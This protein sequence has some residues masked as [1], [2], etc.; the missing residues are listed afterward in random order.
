MDERLAG[1]D[2]GDR[3]N[4]A[5]WGLAPGDRDFG[6]RSWADPRGL[7]RG[8]LPYGFGFG[9][10]VM[11]YLCPHRVRPRSLGARRDPPGGGRQELA[12]RIVTRVLVMTPSRLSDVRLSRLIFWGAGF[13]SPGPQHRPRGLRATRI[14][15]DHTLR[16]PHD[17]SSGPRAHHRRPTHG[18]RNRRPGDTRGCVRPQSPLTTGSPRLRR[19]RNPAGAVGVSTGELNP[20]GPRTPLQDPGILGVV[21][22]GSADDGSAN[23]G[24]AMA[25]REED[26]RQVGA[27]LLDG[28]QEPACLSLPSRS[29]SPCSRDP[30]LEAAGKLLDCVDNRQAPAHSWYISRG[31]CRRGRQR[32]CSGRGIRW[33]RAAAC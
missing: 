27:T 3:W 31:H 25:D 15:H 16:P 17:V 8:D 2:I 33:G 12:A 28:T 32:L 21:V 7:G 20:G 29:C 23:A 10:G 24:A 6:V 5:L 22:G 30:Y 11:I 1:I 9:A 13:C 18:R 14:T 26:E 4:V 19:W